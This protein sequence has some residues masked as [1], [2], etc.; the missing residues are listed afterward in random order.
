[1]APN[2]DLT[3]V[4]LLG[5]GKFRILLMNCR[6]G[7]MSSSV[8]MKPRKLTS[9]RPNWNILWVEGASI[10]RGPGEEVTGSEEVV[11]YVVIINDGVISPCLVVREA[12]QRF[13][14][15]L[16][17]AITSCN[18][19]LGQGLLPVSAPFSDKGGDVT[20]SRV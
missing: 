12:I 16:C 11:F 3:S 4:M 8:T 7:L 5:A 13:R 9:L 18:I 10:S 15:P 20:V 6:V 2:Y 19:V 14:P 1:M 17:V